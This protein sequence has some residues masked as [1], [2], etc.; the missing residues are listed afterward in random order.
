MFLGIDM[1]FSKL[2]R[3]F[4]FSIDRIVYGFIPTIYDLLISIARTS[5]LS[6]ADILSMA[7]RIYDLLAIFMAFKVIFSLIMYVVNPDDFS[8]KTKG[9]SKLATN[10][11]ISLGL[12]ILTPYI[13]RLA[14]QTQ[15]IVLEDN[16]L[17]NLVFGQK[18]DKKFLNSAGDDIAYTIMT[19]F[20]SP[21]VS[22]SGLS[23]CVDLTQKKDNQVIINE[24]CF[25]VRSKTYEE[26]PSDD[27]NNDN[28]SLYDLTKD[29]DNFTLQDLQNYA[30][31]IEHQN[32]PLMFRLGVSKATDKNNE[33]FI[34]DYRYIFSTAVGIVVL[35]IL[36]TFCM[37]V[38][39]RSVKLSFL[40][41]IAPIPI[42]SYVDPKSGKD[43]LFKKWYQMS[44]KTFLSLFLRLLALYFGIYIISRI[45]KMTDIVDGSYITNMW[46]KIFIIIGTLMFVKQLPKILEGLGLKLDG[47]GKFF[48]NPFKKFEEQAAGGKRLTGAVGG[49][50]AG[51]VGG[52]GIRLGSMLTGAARG[53]S[54]NK[55][56]KGGID[57]QAEV[58]RKL[59][60]ARIKGAGFWGSRAAVLSSRYGLD[61]ALLER[62]ATNLRK[63][64]RAVELARREVDSQV[65][66]KEAIKKQ[67]QDQIHKQKETISDHKR[68]QDAVSKME[69]RA[70][71]EIQNGNGGSIG[72][73]YL[74]R[75]AT[76]EYYENNIGKKINGKTITPEMA[77]DARQRANSYLN[78]EG[79]KEYM[80]RASKGKFDDGKDDLTFQNSYKTYEDAARVIGITPSETGSE[81]HAQYGRSKG[82][83][84]DIEREI[85]PT[86]R[87]IT[88]IEDE[89]RNIQVD[90]KVSVSGYDE[91]ISLEEAEQILRDREQELKD[92]QDQGK[93][94]RETAKDR[95]ISSG[96]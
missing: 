69:E 62:E 91:D 21:N 40:Q 66:A 36:V 51:A 83:V 86:E 80:T 76:A 47:D 88:N 58:N 52:R 26:I 93:L 96:S 84:G 92:K 13:F 15:T 49:M 74:T 45:G 95:R 19:P 20:F 23:Q 39:L 67:K 65:K 1:W 27:D 85:A 41:L 38:A 22:I 30:A 10:I 33:T 25:G 18:D 3:H 2:I 24:S 31:G 57:R 35:L 63:D 37:D 17:A 12:L 46:I 82:K 29:N 7:E 43:G 68:M 44:I 90:K 34:I 16:T 56:Y 55:G 11:I 48:L 89:I 72:K 75:K 64:K 59:R 6:Q 61:D 81:I 70:K 8:D 79:M 9:V 4:F 28:K 78:D 94:N 77:A 87:E 54:A 60:E 50:V 53:F 32:L 73:E 5:I 71:S 42:L 14:Y